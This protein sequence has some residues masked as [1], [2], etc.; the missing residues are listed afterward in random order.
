MAN[1]SAPSLAVAALLG[2]AFTSPSALAQDDLRNRLTAGIEMIGRACGD[3]VGSFCGKVTRGEGRLLLCMQAHEDQL[4]RRCQFALYRASRHLE[5]ALH[6]V[7]RIADACWVDIEA[8]CAEADRIGPC[9][10]Q[11][12]ESLSQSCQT[13]VGTVQRLLQGLADLRGA[14]VFGADDKN[15]GKVVDVTRGPDGKIQSIKVE[16]GTALGLGSKVVEINADMI[17]EV[18][19]RVR[20]RI[21]DDQIRSLPAAR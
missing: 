9:I 13:V 18:A 6:K 21:S 1:I 5:N 20:A 3:D 8:Q 14:E 16:I 7:E 19:D 11:K 4:S 2:V 15:L 10:M 17:E 12:K